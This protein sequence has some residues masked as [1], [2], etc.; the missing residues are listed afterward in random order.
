MDTIIESLGVFGIICVL[1]LIWITVSL[2]YRLNGTS[3]KCSNCNGNC[4]QGKKCSCVVC[5]CEKKNE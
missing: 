2:I 5:T 1:L 4:E 3:N